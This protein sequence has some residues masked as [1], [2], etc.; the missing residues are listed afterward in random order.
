MDRDGEAGAN[1]ASLDQ[2]VD[3]LLRRF[4]R[5]G[6]ADPVDF[7][8][9]RYDLGL[10][11]VHFSPGCGGSGAPRHEQE[12]IERRLAEAGAPAPL[13]DYVGLHQAAEAVHSAG[14][15]AQRDRF[16]R[17]TF[18]GEAHWCQLF[19]EPGAGSDLAALATSAVRDGPS[20][21]VNGQKVWTSGARHADWAILLARTDPDLPKHRGMTLFVCDMRAPGV[22]VRA[23]RQ[24][25]GGAHFSEVFLTD[26]LVPD[27]LRLGEVGAG[28]GVSLAAMSSER[29]GTA[30]LFRRPV[31]EL[32]DLW[33][34][35][36]DSS[37][38][39]GMARRDQVVRAWI[40]ARVAEAPLEP[41]LAK[42]AASEQ[43]QRQS[44]TLASV[45]GMDAQ[46][47]V[48][49]GD[50]RDE[51]EGLDLDF[52]GM[53][54]PRFVVRARAM[55]IEGGTNEIQRNIVGER[56]LGLPGDVRVDK[57]RPWREVPRS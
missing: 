18:A 48:D 7:M 26:V 55:S 4:P 46:V 27:D 20:W 13:A 39:A 41:S 15:G 31:T 16:L 44:G 19:S 17:A 49:Y 54:A 1:G 23:L 43:C 2:R 45:M 22:E 8:L 6:E 12:R 50:A 34:A 21:M 35:R 56:V 36:P 40:E 42:V 51:G 37:T 47:G 32:V 33:A 29:A 24:A 10:A 25:D 14:T 57:D 9:A 5:L 3:E 38:A 28:W 52:A 30:T 53:A 11:W